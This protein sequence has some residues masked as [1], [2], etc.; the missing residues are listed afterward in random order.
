M[1]Q[2]PMPV[3]RS[4]DERL[5]HR[6]WQALTKVPKITIYF[7]IIKILT[8]A[9]GESTSDY[10]V[11]RFNSYLA[12]ISGFIVFAIVLAFQFKKR[13][14]VPW[15][16]WLAVTMVAVFGTMTADV[17]HIEFG[18][19]YIVSTVIFA[20]TLAIIFA[21][22]YQVEGTLSFHSIHTRRREAF[23]WVAVLA[24]FAMGTAIGDFTAYAAH[25]GF[26]SSGL[27]FTVVFAL[28]AIGYWLFKLN[29]VLA[30]WLAYILTRPIGASFADW[31]GKPHSFGGLNFGDGPVA[32]VLATFIIALVLYLSLSSK[33]T[34]AAALKDDS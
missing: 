26:F 4:I 33:D 8:T 22:W 27:L 20:I 19:P 16:Y 21:A 15:V 31:T 32:F 23:Y 28:P 11:H 3:H 29:A 13:S 30:F 12:V 9:M 7:W 18:V 2:Q 10:L 17:T 34:Q 24:T 6:S 25:L 14:Y 1:N 5:K